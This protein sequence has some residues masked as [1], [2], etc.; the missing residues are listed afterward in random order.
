MWQRSFVLFDIITFLLQV[1]RKSS[2]FKQSK[3]VKKF[4]Q[5][6]K[7]LDTLSIYVVRVISVLND[8]I[9]NRFNFSFTPHPHF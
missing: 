5:K 3:Q 2:R 4:K 7:Q 6:Y 8:T 1:A 9:N